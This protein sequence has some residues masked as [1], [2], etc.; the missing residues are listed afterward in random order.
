MYIY[1]VGVVKFIR[2]SVEYC[3][4]VVR[5]FYIYVSVRQKPYSRESKFI[6]RIRTDFILRNIENRIYMYL[7]VR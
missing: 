4:V 3:V 5:S 6:E 2:I 7:F 1:I